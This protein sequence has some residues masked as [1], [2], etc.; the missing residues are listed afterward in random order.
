MVLSSPNSRLG[1]VNL[2]SD[3]ILKKIPFKEK[4]VIQ[5]SDCENF[6]V[7]KGKT[8]YKNVLNLTEILDEIK[9]KYKKIFTEELQLSRI[10]DLVEYGVELQKIDS[11]TLN[12]YKT[13][14]CIYNQNQIKKFEK[15]STKSYS[16]DYN[17]TEYSENL[18]VSSCF[19]HGYSL[20]NGRN[21]Y[22]FGKYIIYNLSSKYLNTKLTLT[23]S[24]ENKKFSIFDNSSLV[25]DNDLIEK[26]KSSYDFNL[27]WLEKEIK[28][29]D[30][31][32]ETTDP[33]SEH[34]FLLKN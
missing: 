1:I 12:F 20:N 17:A 16:D 25:I 7:I 22:Y 32:L 18:F 3:F 15:N 33:L 29:V 4:S 28:K 13:K 23:L 26:I 6:F 5:V 8:S 21:L 14:N 11:I 2:I 31:C 34:K 9:K 30:W 27:K 19:P 10:I 24:E